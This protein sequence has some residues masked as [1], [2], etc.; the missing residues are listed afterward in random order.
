MLHTGDLARMGEDGLLYIV[1]RKK[2]LII[3]GGFN[4]Y[5]KEVE[6]VLSTH[7]D[8]AAAAVFGTPDEKWGEA[9]RAVVAVRPGS[10]V[11]PQMLI[12]FVRA[13]K[14]AVCTPK[15]IEF[16]DQIPVT[17]LG[18]PDKK[19]LRSHYWSHQSRGIA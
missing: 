4:V 14:G 13:K 15:S 1:D 16:V 3:S 9:V 2:D 5:P 7:P 8:V 18:K 11:T 17:S 10:N 19:A 6:D 12:E